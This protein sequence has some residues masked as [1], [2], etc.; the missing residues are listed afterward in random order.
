MTANG[1]AVTPPVDFSF[2]NLYSIEEMSS[3]NPRRGVKRY[4]RAKSGRLESHALRLNNNQL[5]SIQ[6][7]NAISY[8]VLEQPEKLTWL[9][10][11]F[12]NLASLSSDLS[13]FSSLKILYLH[14]NQLR[15]LNHVLTILSTLQ[16]LYNLT[17][18][19]NPL[20][21]RKRYKEQLIHRLPNLRSLDFTNVTQTDRRK[22]RNKLDTTAL[23]RRNKV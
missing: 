17:L 20:Q 6:G 22:T 21:E 2:L 3:K 12:N 23:Y 1:T 8:Q 18:H 4:H 9:D 7:I 11:S 14:G 10:L 5:T 16:H 15:H 19:G 13:A